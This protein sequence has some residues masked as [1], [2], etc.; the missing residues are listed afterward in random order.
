MGKTSEEDETL[1]AKAKYDG[2]YKD[3]QKHGYGRFEFP[4]G[5]VYEGGWVENKVTLT[6][7]I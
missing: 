4:N 3:G 6:F 7:P 2:N 1:I 5:D